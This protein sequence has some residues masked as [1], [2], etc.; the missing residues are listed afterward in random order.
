MR[1]ISESLFRKVIN[2]AR[3]SPRRRKN[4]NFHQYKDRVQ[5]II[6]V[7]EPDTYVRPHKHEKP[8][9][10]E[11]FIALRGKGLFVTFT[12]KGKIK[13]YTVISSQG[14]IWGV[15][16]PPRTWHALIA[17]SKDSVFYE[18]IE[19]PYK[20]STH[21]KFPSWAPEDGEGGREYN[22]TIR[23]NLGYD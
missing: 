14:P 21:K 17:L 20:E 8:D 16:I 11:V 22:R 2:Q 23:K 10:V 12:D 9:K 7:L 19:G 3:K 18:V 4:Y 13:N 1:K 6:N 15:E 5:R